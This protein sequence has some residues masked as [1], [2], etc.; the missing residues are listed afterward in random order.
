MVLTEEEKKEYLINYQP[1]P[2]FSSVSVLV[3]LFA[4]GFCGAVVLTE[5]NNLGY[6]HV[7]LD[8]IQKMLFFVI[9]AFIVMQL[10]KYFFDKKHEK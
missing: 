3:L 5:L 7:D 4:V 9:L 1:T 8:N 2:Q 10:I 6:T